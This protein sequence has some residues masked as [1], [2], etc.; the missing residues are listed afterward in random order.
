MNNMH[1]KSLKKAVAAMLA[2]LWLSPVAPAQNNK[3]EQVGNGVTTGDIH[4]VSFADDQ[5]AFAVGAAGT[6]LKSTDKG[7][8]WSTVNAGTTQSLNAVQFPTTTT[9][10]IAGAGGTM[11]KTTDGGNNW[12]SIAN[13]LPANAKGSGEL[14]G[15]YFKDAVN[16][17]VVGNPG[18]ILQTTDGGNTWYSRNSVTDDGYLRSLSFTNSTTA[19]AV[20][21]NGKIKISIDGGVTWKDHTPSDTP[22][23]GADHILC[24][25][26][27][28]SGGEFG[29]VYPGTYNAHYAYPGTADLDYFKS[30]NLKLIRFPF[31]W[32][33][34]Q[35]ERNGAL[36]EFDLNH[37][38]TFVKAAEDRDLPIILDMHNFARRAEGNRLIL[39]HTDVTKEHLA[40]CWKKLAQEFKSYTNIWGYDIM[41]EPYNMHKDTPWFDIAQAVIYAIREI[42]T[43]TPIII[44]GDR[45]SSPFHWMQYSDNLKNLV[46]PSDNLIFQAHLYF[47]EDFSGAY[48]VTV[49]GVA[50]S[51]TYEQEKAYPEIGVDR[52]KPFVNWLKQ[53]NKRGMVGE[54]GIPS[55]AADFSKWS[56]VLDKFLKYLYD[57]KIPGTYWSAGPRWGGYRLSVQPTE[58]YTVDRPQMQILQNYTDIPE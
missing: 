50:V 9:G 51:S 23:P 29:S 3:W 4:A 42:D 31:R 39:I 41:N 20:G 25:G 6:L 40:D 16:G 32:E 17:F 54:Y 34:I 21:N 46:D 49:D 53:N 1:R 36:N 2:V 22:N 48:Q 8:T 56:V 10:Y 33:R 12:T 15:I 28:L 18:L 47:D 13:N 19:Y 58:N 55:D 38:K 26:V 27:N 7:V 57:N 30:K 52:M 44:S 45:Y 11:L 35:H 37:M 14:L 43:K 5:K 24:F